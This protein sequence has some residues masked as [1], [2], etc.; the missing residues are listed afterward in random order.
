MDIK[1][2][3]SQERILWALYDAGGFVKKVPPDIA[4]PSGPE[5][6]EYYRACEWLQ[7][8]GFILDATDEV[9]GRTANVAFYALRLTDLGKSYCELHRARLQK[10]F[11]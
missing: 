2:D 1:L 7:S 9:Y 6:Q 5:R 10:S 4:P 3:P 8:Q 11:G